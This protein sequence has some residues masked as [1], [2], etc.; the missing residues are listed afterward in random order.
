LADVALSLRENLS[1]AQFH[2][3]TIVNASVLTLTLPALTLSRPAWQPNQLYRE[4]SPA[5]AQNIPL[6]L[7]P[8]FAWANRGDTEMSVWLPAR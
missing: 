6:K 7:I 8:Y 1:S 5:T 4:A 2:R 3:E